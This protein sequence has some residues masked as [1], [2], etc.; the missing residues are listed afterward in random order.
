VTL[1]EA[2]VKVR[3]F[4]RTQTGVDADPDWMKR[5]KNDNGRKVWRA[6]YSAKHFYA[7]EMAPGVTVD[8]GEYFV[9]IDSKTGAIAVWP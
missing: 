2:T 3:E 6:L 5:T 7:E 4:V 8:G 9:E 1:Q